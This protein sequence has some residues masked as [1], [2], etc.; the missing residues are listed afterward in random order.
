MNDNSRENALHLISF[1]NVR[2]DWAYLAEKKL[3][4]VAK[5]TGG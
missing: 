5:I 2:K 1:V 3:L 4:P